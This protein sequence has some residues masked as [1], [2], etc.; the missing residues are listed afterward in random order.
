MYRGGTRL[1]HHPRKMLKM[2]DWSKYRDWYH[3]QIILSGFGEIAQ[4]KLAASHVAIVGAGGLGSPVLQYLSAAGVGEI[5]IIDGDKI[6]LT[7]LHR[8][9]LYGID[10]VGKPKASTAA[11]KIKKNY[12]HIKIHA[13]DKMLDASIAREVFPSVDVIIDATDNFPSR[14]FIN[15]ACVLTGKPIVFA[16]I[17]KFQLQLSVFNYQH[18]P[19]LRCVFPEPPS[20]EDSPDCQTTGILGPVAGIAGVWQAMETV[21]ILTGQGNVFSQRLFILDLFENNFQILN[22]A[23]NERLWEKQI[24]QTWEQLSTYDYGTFCGLKQNNKNTMQFKDIV[25]SGQYVILDLREEHERPRIKASNVLNIA[26]PDLVHRWQELSKDKIYVL[27]CQ[28]GRRSAT[29]QYVLK[30]TPLRWMVWEGGVN[31]IA[32]KEY[33]EF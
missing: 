10:D 20:P 5:T 15:D 17:F 33:L 24:P 18:G 26:L 9:I 19:T 7:N 4:K 29:A 2:Y 32:E 1:C 13:I 23:R 3:R 11:S 27:I 6:D 31:N 12:P 16:S 30:N 8:Q 25:N 22:I 14:Y 21:K 28:S